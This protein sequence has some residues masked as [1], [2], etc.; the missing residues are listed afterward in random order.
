[1]L[2]P[3]PVAIRLAW[4]IDGIEKVITI[5]MI[6]VVNV[7]ITVGACPAMQYTTEVDG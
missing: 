4:D 1:M 7:Q 6:R 5:Q 3:T 2:Y